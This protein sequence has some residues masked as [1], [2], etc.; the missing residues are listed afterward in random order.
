[1]AH[2]RQSLSVFCPL[3]QS[4]SVC[5]VEWDGNDFHSGQCF[6]TEKGEVAVTRPAEALELPRPSD[7]AE[8]ALA[9]GCSTAVKQNPV[10]TKQH[11]GFEPLYA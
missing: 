6:R 3:S 11:K 7:K 8:I 9:Q 1:M 2:G 5:T 10:V 4:S